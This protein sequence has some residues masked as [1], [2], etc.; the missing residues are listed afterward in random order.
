MRLRRT[1]DGARWLNVEGIETDSEDEVETEFAGPNVD[2]T[3]SMSTKCQWREALLYNY[4][5]I[6]LPEGENATAEFDRV[7]N[8]SIRRDRR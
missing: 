4:G 8:Q 6:S 3:F 7:W 1:R 5:A 2:S